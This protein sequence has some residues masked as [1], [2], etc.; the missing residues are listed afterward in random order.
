MG[1]CL[2]I[3]LMGMMGRIEPRKSRKYTKKKRE[4]KTR[5]LLP[6]RAFRL[7]RGFLC[8]IRCLGNNVIITDSHYG[9]HNGDE[10][11]YRLYPELRGTHPAM[12]VIRTVKSEGWSGHGDV[13]W[14]V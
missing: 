11:A 1:M 5:S 3:L 2:G 7:F 14:N 4:L 8:L 10:A 12:R 9:L 13:S 6:F